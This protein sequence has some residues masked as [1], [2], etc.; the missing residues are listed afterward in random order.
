MKSDKF[1]EKTLLSFTDQAQGASV[2]KQNKEKFS[3]KHVVYLNYFNVSSELFILWKII[4][5]FL[6]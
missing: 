2:V 6:H 3:R 4:Y 5:D 1:G